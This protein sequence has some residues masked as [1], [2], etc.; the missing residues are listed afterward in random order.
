MLRSTPKVTTPPLL[1][2]PPSSFDDASSSR[3]GHAEHTSSPR[4]MKDL[5]VYILRGACICLLVYMCSASHDVFSSTNAANF[6]LSILPSAC[7]DTKNEGQAVAGNQ[8]EKSLTV[9]QD[10]LEDGQLE[11]FKQT[12]NGTNPIYFDF[13]LSDG[14]DTKF[15]LSKGYSTVSVDAFA[16]WI[17]KAKGE[18]ETEVR[19]GR[20]LFFNVGVSTKDEDSMKLYFKSEGSV[21]SSFEPSKGCQ[22]MS[23]S[24]PQCKHVDV[25]VVRCEALFALVDRAATFVKV[26]IEMLHHSCVRGLS[27]LPTS[28]LPRVVCWEEHDKPFGSA[29]IRRPITDVKL[30]L[31]MYE[32]GYNGVKVVL[33]GY[34]APKF[35]N[36]SIEQTGGGQQSGNLSPDEMMHYRSY[37]KIINEGKFDSDWRSVEHILQEGMFASGR[38]K[39]PHFFRASYYDV[40]MKLGPDAEGRREV[41]ERSDNFP[42]SSYSTTKK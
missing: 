41:L 4:E 18:F 23:T 26:D 20:A 10:L 21:I 40:C 33:Q 9:L 37:E 8:L 27:N 25:A 3:K 2:N 42:L 7:N 30:M 14:K 19:D 36:L 22:G 12:Q 16:P 38:D 17:E 11:R 13:G 6:D 15:H 35:Y 29:K 5:R 1:V 24:N 39:A 28:L 34:K 31:G 32:L